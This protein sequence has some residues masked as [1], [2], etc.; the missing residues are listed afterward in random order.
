MDTTEQVH[1]HYFFDNM[2]VDKAKRLYWLILDEFKN[3]SN[4]N[5]IDN[6]KGSI[7]SLENFIPLDDGAYRIEKNSQ[8]IKPDVLSILDSFKH[9][10]EDENNL[11]STAPKYRENKRLD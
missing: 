8:Q 2:S 9:R 10:L 3:D 11:Q 6:L 5:E 4:G 7:S 1:G